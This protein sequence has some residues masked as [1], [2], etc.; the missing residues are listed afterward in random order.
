MILLRSLVATAAAILLASCQTV[1]PAQTQSPDIGVVQA[2]DP[3]AAEA[4][5]EMLRRGG[6]AT[7]A[8]IAVML[9]LTVVEPQ[10]S[11]IGGGGFMVRGLPDGTVTTFDGRETAPAA[12]GPEWFFGADGEPQSYSEVVLTGL[13]VGVP[14]NI[15]LAAKAHAQHGKLPWEDLFGP[16]ITLAEGFTMNRRLYDSLDGSIERAGQDP[17]MRSTFYTDAGAPRA[18]GSTI[19]RPE[20][21]ETFRRLAAEGP[22]AL[23][24][25]DNAEALA[26]HVAANTPGSA[27]M[28]AA[29]ISGYEAK[30]R[31]AV[32][33][34]YRAYRICSMGP[35]TSGGIALLQILGQLERFDLAELGPE[36][37]TFWHLFA[38][39]QLLA[40]AD[41]EMYAGDSD[42]VSVPV[43]ELVD[44]DYL[45]TRSSLIDPDRALGSY[46]AGDPVGTLA[47]RAD[48]DEPEEHGTTHFV[49]VD[50]NGAMVSYTSTVEGGFGS[51]LQFGGYYLNNELT[52]FSFSPERGD[53]PVANRVEGGK[54]PRSSMSPAMVW[55][56]D[57]E[58]FLVIGGA[59]G[60]FIPVQTA[61]SI[62]GIIDF[63][64]GLEEAFALPIVMGFGPNLFVESDTWLAG[65]ADALEELG[66]GNIRTGPQ[67]F[68]SVGQVGAINAPGGWTGAYDP[69]F[70]ERLEA[71][72]A[73]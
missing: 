33:G 24:G 38:Q 11:G 26:A 5:R 68:G 21:A 18:V 56:P 57:G 64:M 23:Y 3:R 36:S 13:S 69:R 53:R 54:R 71:T 58:P 1:P 25:P 10:S 60:P 59:G 27:A 6:S 45:A 7:D 43:K 67:P 46:E 52:D 8:A 12:A 66:Y 51:G 4:G 42:F 50:R 17:L 19:R 28:T 47:L 30:E 72:P 22:E 49:A 9:A 62:I 29:D 40:Y 2:A 37:V 39:S 14:G 20:L 41:R 15:A 44:P 16:A 70:R 31:E 35:P 34:T 73:R 63:D 61:R 32:C 65:E 55:A 48:G